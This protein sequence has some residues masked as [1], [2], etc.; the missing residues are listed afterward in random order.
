MFSSVCNCKDTKYI[1]I[2]WYASPITGAAGKNKLK[3]FLVVCVDEELHSISSKNNLGMYWG[4]VR[5]P[6]PKLFTANETVEYSLSAKHI[7]GIS[8]AHSHQ[9]Y[10]WF[11][12]S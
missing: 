8:P 1:D 4:K 2:S 12:F 7:W 3:F 11:E 10:Y 6:L 9:L 5:H